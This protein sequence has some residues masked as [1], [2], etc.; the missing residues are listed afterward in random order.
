MLQ[1]GVTAMNLIFTSTLLLIELGR[2]SCLAI[3]ELKIN[4]F[5]NFDASENINDKDFLDVD[6]T[7]DFLPSITEV[8]DVPD[9]KVSTPKYI[10]E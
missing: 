1:G 9:E 6:V 5:L 2:I 7:S 8:L 3:N 10:R 4:N